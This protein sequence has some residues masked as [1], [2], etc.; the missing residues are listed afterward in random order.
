MKKQWRVLPQDVALVDELARQCGLPHF[1]AQLLIRRGLVEPSLVGS[2]LDPKLTDLRDPELLPGVE[3]ASR[4]LHRAVVDGKSIVIY[5]DYDADGMT[6][7]AILL[8][9]LRLMGANVSY[10]VPNRL[11]D[12]YGLSEKALRKLAELGKQM[13]VTVDCGIASIAEAKVCRELGLELIITDHHTMGGTLPE[14]AAIVHPGLPGHAYPFRGLCGAGV[15][16]KLAWALCQQ[17]SQAKKVSPEFRNYL[18]SAVGLAAIG[19]VA[20]VVPLVD[21]NRVLVRHGLKALKQSPTPGILA[22]MRVTKLDQ[23]STL[24]SDSIAFTLAPRLNAAGRLGQA[25]LGVE[26]LTTTDP[27]RAEALAVYIDKLNSDR[28]TLERSMQLAAGK[29]IKEQYDV[30]TTPA[31]VL[32]SPGWHAGV[33]GVVAGRLCEKHHLPVVVISLDPLGQKPGIGS[34]RAPKYLNLH[35]AFMACSEYL[36][37]HGGHAAAAGLKIE[38]PNLAAFREAFCEYVSSHT[39][40][41]STVPELVIDAESPLGMITMQTVKQLEAM[42]PFGQDNP[43]PVLCATQVRLAEPARHLGAG[44]HHFAANFKQHGTT[45][46]AVAFGQ[47]EWVSQFQDTSREYDIAFRPVLNEYRGYLSIQLHLVDWRIHEP[48]GGAVAA[49]GPHFLHVA[50]AEERKR[51]SE[52]AEGTARRD[53]PEVL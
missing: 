5:G 18:M 40:P 33:I 36:V 26:L 9:A 49:A 8:G 45:H 21:E 15:A 46:R 35:E 42:A 39:T 20:D 27:S 41:A 23:R 17:A 11:E 44:E 16:F 12:G 53:A 22:L 2:F 29:Q 14:A 37:T 3:L 7:T 52:G 19:T 6:S 4:L 10:F 38:E 1:L 51:L 48:I 31:L 47:G 28:E 24:E 50:G 25:Q 32:A 43:R 34:A 30:G 13:V